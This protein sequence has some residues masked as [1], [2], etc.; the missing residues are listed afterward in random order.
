MSSVQFGAVSIR[1]KS[2]R[3]LPRT[4]QVTFVSRDNVL[5]LAVLQAHSAGAASRQIRRH[6]AGADIFEV[7]AS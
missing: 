6:F 2:G 3:D 7:V 4:Y 1:D 5:T